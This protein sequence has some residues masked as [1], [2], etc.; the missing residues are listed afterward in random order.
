MRT[1]FRADPEV[2]GE[3]LGVDQASASRA[4]L[5]VTLLVQCSGQGLLHAAFPSGVLAYP[6]PDQDAAASRSFTT[7][8]SARGVLAETMTSSSSLT[9]RSRS[10][11]PAA[12]SREIES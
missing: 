3:P 6:A 4:D 12:S 2:A 11:R 1:A 8:S 9:P 5:P 10:M 7:A